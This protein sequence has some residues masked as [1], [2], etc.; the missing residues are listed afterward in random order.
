MDKNGTASVNTDSQWL[1]L[2]V[3]L[4]CGSLSIATPVSLLANEFN[5]QSLLHRQVSLTA[6]NQIYVIHEAMNGCKKLK[7]H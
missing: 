1:V 3:W 7:I 4:G 5:D 2:H 6:V